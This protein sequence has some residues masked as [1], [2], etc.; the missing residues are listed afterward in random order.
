MNVKKPK[1]RAG[2]VKSSATASRKDT[3]RHAVSATS[4][5]NATAPTASSTTESTVKPSRWVPTERIPL[6]IT[7]AK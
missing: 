5:T 6:A 4:T 7:R 2:S 1:P 3:R